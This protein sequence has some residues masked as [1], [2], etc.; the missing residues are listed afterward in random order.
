M[1]IALRRAANFAASPAILFYVL[2]WLMALVVA[3]TVT[4]PALGLHESVER[5]IASWTV[6]GFP[7]LPGG[8]PTLGLLTINL[9]ARFLFR[10]EWHWRKAGIHLTHLGV[11]V[12]LV[13][14]L[15]TMLTVQ[16]GYMV[17]P[18]G[19]TS[20]QIYAFE[21]GEIA[22]TPPS[23]P[24]ES[25]IWGKDLA[26]L[27]FSLT[28]EHFTR[29]TYPGTDTPKTYQADVVVDN[30]GVR[31]PAR[32]GMNEPLRLRGYTIYQSSF[33][34]V[35]E[36]RAT[37]LQTVKNQGVVLPY[38]AGLLMLAGLLLHLIVMSKERRA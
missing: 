30:D 17:I 36:H 21:K 2:P 4:Q 35:G 27:P 7:F 22:I 24:G 34:D 12:L 31:F 29:E 15:V 16:E 13:G 1:L 19:R 9:C 5:F 20:D 33:I 14:G 10:S 8:L 25:M 28:L 26:K 18:E 6:P 38:V 37:V 32:I 11:L 23:K 3:A